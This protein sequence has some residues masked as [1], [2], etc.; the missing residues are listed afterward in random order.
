MQ[1][2]TIALI[3]SRD[4]IFLV[5]SKIFIYETRKGVFHGIIFPKKKSIFQFFG[6]NICTVM[7]RK[8]DRDEQRNINQLASFMN[9]IILWQPSLSYNG[10]VKWSS[11]PEV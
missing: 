5:D 7:E 9:K 2:S 11:L 6:R 1:P 8:S 10:S 3:L 4:T